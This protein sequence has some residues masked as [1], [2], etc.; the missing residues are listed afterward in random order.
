MVVTISYVAI[1]MQDTG[2]ILFC[3]SLRSSWSCI[4]MIILKF[5][6]SNSIV[7]SESKS[8]TFAPVEVAKLIGN[9]KRPFATQRSS[10]VCASVVLPPT[11]RFPLILFV[12]YLPPN[13]ESCLI[14]CGEFWTITHREFVQVRAEDSTLG[15]RELAGQGRNK[16]G[17]RPSRT[18]RIEGK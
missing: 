16:V 13:G 1:L 14:L 5:N 18:L 4:R 15:I 10:P 9:Y 12:S 6:V 3:S 7:I 17:P 11:M 8:H 2:Q